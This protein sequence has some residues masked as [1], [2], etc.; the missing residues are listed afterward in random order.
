[1]LRTS[2]KEKVE[3]FR[4]TMRFYRG[5]TVPTRSASSVI[6]RIRT[7]GLLPGDGNWRMSAADLKGR[8]EEIWRKPKVTCAD[9]KPTAGN[10]GPLWVCA[11]AEEQGALYY[12]CRHNRS[13][14]N[15]TPILISFDAEASDAIVDGR[16]FLYTAFQLSDAARAR[17]VLERLFGPAILRYADRAWN[18]H[19]DERIALCDLAV[20]DSAVVLAHADNKALFAGRS[21]TQFRSAFLV[22][23]PVPA[24]RIADVRVVDVAVELPEP[25]VVLTDLIL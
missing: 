24:A 12:A 23:T 1:L 10:P 13:G 22:R 14:E 8:L 15:D 21:G 7:Q 2:P 20:Q 4:K 19:G 11:C 16:D 17:A 5:I 18:V 9:T 25:D 3:H 6:D